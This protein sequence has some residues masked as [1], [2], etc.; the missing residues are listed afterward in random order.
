MF[1]ALEAEARLLSPSQLKVLFD[2]IKAIQISMD[3]SEVQEMEPHNSTHVKK[4]FYIVDSVRDLQHQLKLLSSE[5]EKLQATLTSHVT[6]IEHLKDEVESHLRYKLDS[7]K[8]ENELSDVIFTLEKIIGKLGGEL[9]GDQ[10]SSGAK[11]LLSVVEQ[12]V[13]ALILEY[14]S[15][16][17]KAQELD[18]KLIGSQRIVD[19]LS[20]KVKL[21]EDSLQGRAAQAEIIQERSIL[22]APSLPTGPEISEIEDA[23]CINFHVFKHVRFWPHCC[24]SYFSYVEIGTKK[25]CQLPW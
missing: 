9:V 11:G 14:E 10:K 17:S 1:V 23:V 20:T 18:V 3:E 2:K 5:K 12:Q 4:L 22:E 21:L 6:E 25:S 16:K 13:M 24:Y 8:M 15:S 7:E 19:E